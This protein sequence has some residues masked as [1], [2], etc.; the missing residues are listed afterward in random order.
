[1]HLKNSVMKILI[2]FLKDV[3]KL[4]SIVNVEMSFQKQSFQVDEEIED[5]DLL[6]QKKSEE[7]EGHIKRQCRRLSCDG[8]ISEED[9]EELKSLYSIYV[10]NSDPKKIP[11]KLSSEELDIFC[12]FITVLYKSIFDIFSD[13]LGN[14]T[15]NLKYLIKYC[16]DLLSS[17]RLKNYFGMCL[18]K[19]YLDYDPYLFTTQSE[20]YLKF[21]E[22]FLFKIQVPLILKTLVS[23]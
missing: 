1:M 22:K 17:Q 5:P 16:V 4:L 3:Q 10:L 14:F 12:I 11:Q 9:K 13:N 19:F 20:L 2:K 7:S 15:D 8:N 18:D 21:H 23:T 6:A